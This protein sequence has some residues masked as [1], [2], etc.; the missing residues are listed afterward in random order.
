MQPGQVAAQPEV[1][2]PVS[3]ISSRRPPPTTS[4]CTFESCGQW[5]A[6]PTSKLTCRAPSLAPPPPSLT[7][8]LKGGGDN[9]FCRS[10]VPNSQ[11][12]TPNP[13][14]GLYRCPI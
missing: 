8:P 10:P 13:Q 4:G 1:Q 6:L 11:P 2:P 3:A 14:R 7:L 9:S 5:Y 12:P